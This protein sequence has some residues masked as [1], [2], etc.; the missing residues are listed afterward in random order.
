MDTLVENLSNC[1]DYFLRLSGVPDLSG[2]VFLITFKF[3]SLDYIMF[4]NSNLNKTV[5]FFLVLLKRREFVTVKTATLYNNFIFFIKSLKS[6]KKNLALSL[7][8]YVIREIWL[9][10]SKNLICIHQSKFYI[11]SHPQEFKNVQHNFKIF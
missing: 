2:K 11:F 6:K 4:C 1:C 8:Y 3:S 9:G 10:N 5:Y 7:S